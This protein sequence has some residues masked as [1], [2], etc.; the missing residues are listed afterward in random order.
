[1]GYNRVRSVHEERDSRWQLEQRQHELARLLCQPERTHQH[2]QQ[3][4]FPP[5]ENRRIAQW[6]CVYACTMSPFASPSAPSGAPYACCTRGQN[7]QH[8][9]SWVGTHP[10]L[11]ACA[12][13]TIGVFFV[14]TKF[15]CTTQLRS[16]WSKWLWSLFWHGS[17][18]CSFAA[19]RSENDEHDD[20]SVFASS[21][22]RSDQMS[23]DLCVHR[24]SEGGAIVSFCNKRSHSRAKKLQ[25]IRWHLVRDT[26]GHVHVL[27]RSIVL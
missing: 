22:S 16:F 5:L 1:M 7:M 23:R 15:R 10:M 11:D 26:A 17:M 19:R 6:S 14:F 13:K 24:S 21:L 8:A 12:P 3:R 25:S 4:G 27:P 2:E 18:S 9:L 20:R